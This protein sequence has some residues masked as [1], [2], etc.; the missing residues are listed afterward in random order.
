MGG[1]IMNSV[2]QL[3]EDITSAVAA[4]E[5]LRIDK[6]R[7]RQLLSRAVQVSCN[8]G[9]TMILSDRISKSSFGLDN[10]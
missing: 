8:C 1:Q 10:T 5:H 7:F 3:R 2:L 4:Q 6:V 9:A